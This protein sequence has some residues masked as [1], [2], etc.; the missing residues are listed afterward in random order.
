MQLYQIEFLEKLNDR[1]IRQ[2]EYLKEMY[3]I[4]D[5]AERK[6][7]R[8]GITAYLNGIQDAGQMTG[9]EYKTLFDYCTL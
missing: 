3:H 2:L 7:F 4:S 5:K 6:K 1:E 9:K 8:F